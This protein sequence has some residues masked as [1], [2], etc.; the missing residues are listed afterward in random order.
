[1]K[2]FDDY[3]REH[4]EVFSQTLTEKD[5]RKSRQLHVT[6]TPPVRKQHSPVPKF[7]LSEQKHVTFEDTKIETNNDKKEHTFPTFS[8]K[9]D[10]GSEE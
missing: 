8:N 2:K 7:D 4:D 3:C 6:E 5:I 9:D 1:M 10:Y